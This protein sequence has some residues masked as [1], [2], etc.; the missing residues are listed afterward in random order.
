MMRGSVTTAC[1]LLCPQWCCGSC[2]GAVAVLIKVIYLVGM[3][4]GGGELVG[5]LIGAGGLSYG[6]FR[7]RRSVTFFGG[8]TSVQIFD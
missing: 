3:R 5:W 4:G 2:S 6:T 1:R 8:C 7:A